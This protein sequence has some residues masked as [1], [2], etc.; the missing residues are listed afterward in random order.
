M[1]AVLRVRLCLDRDGFLYRL[2]RFLQFDRREI[3]LDSPNDTVDGDC[4]FLLSG[5]GAGT[6][7][8]PLCDALEVAIY[9]GF[10]LQAIRS[11]DW[12]VTYRRVVFLR[13]HDDSAFF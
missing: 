3:S 9:V 13:R 8:S 7:L 11:W 12:L 5:D 6:L 2:P 1:G 10:C 4:T